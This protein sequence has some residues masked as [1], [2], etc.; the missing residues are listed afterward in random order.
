M[1]P[2]LGLRAGG[3]QDPLANRHDQPGFLGQRNEAR[4]RHQAFLT[5]R[6]PAQQRLDPENPPRLHAQQRLVVQLKFIALQRPAQAPFQIKALVSNAGQGSSVEA[7]G[8]TPLLLGLMHGGIGMLQQFG[9]GTA[10]LRIQADTD[11]GIDVHLLPGRQ[12]E[13]FD[14]QRKQNLGGRCG[15]LGSVQVLQHH[16]EL[17]A[18]EPR[19]GILVAQALAHALGDGTQQFITDRMA[20]TVVDVLEAVQIDEQHAHP[21]PIAMRPFHGMRQSRL[22]EQAIGQT[23]ERVIVRQLR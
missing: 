5:G 1:P 11:A 13:G 9:G 7:I 18:T 3:A 8:V 22:S 17:I 14:Q 4:R 23:G 2:G 6:L 16:Q 15:I 10:I 12:R 21:L 19:Q 20:E